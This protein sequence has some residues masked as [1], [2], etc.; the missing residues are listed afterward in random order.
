MTWDEAE[1]RVPPAV[2]TFL[3]DTNARPSL[4]LIGWMLL[5]MMI[6][7]LSADNSSLHPSHVPLWLEH[8][9]HPAHSCRPAPTGRS[10]YNT[11]I[12]ANSLA[13]IPCSFNQHQIS[14]L[15]PTWYVLSHTCTRSGRLGVRILV[16]ARGLSL[17]VKV[18]TVR[19]S[20]P[21]QLEPGLSR[22]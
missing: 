11:S 13:A 12:I 22:G 15:V 4:G 19:S 7:D 8:K 17:L 21:L 2:V 14:P 5:L 18:Q 20:H 6:T 10:K 16:G 3:P 1:D 9:V